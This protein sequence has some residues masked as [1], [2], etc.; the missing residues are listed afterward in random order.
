MHSSSPRNYTQTPLYGHPHNT[1]TS[2]LRT[3]FHVP[4]KRIPLTF[5]PNS[6][7]LIRTPRQS[8]HFLWPPR[9]T[10]GSRLATSRPLGERSEPLLATK[11]PTASDEVARGPA[12]YEIRRRAFLKVYAGS[13]PWDKVGGPVTPTLRWRGGGGV[14]KKFLRALVWS[15]NKGGPVP[16]GPS[17]GSATTVSAVLTGF[18]F[19]LASISVASNTI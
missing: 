5:S 4:G 16:P 2:L 17:P 12:P 7:R 1:E 3:V 9:W 18:D 13:R 6:T 8:G 15:K 19:I 14:S 11:R 10:A